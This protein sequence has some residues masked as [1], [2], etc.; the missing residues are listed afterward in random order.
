VLLVNAVGRHG[1]TD[2]W[3]ARA[4][5]PPAVADLDGDHFSVM[6]AR[7]AERLAAMLRLE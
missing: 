5:D 3:V 6:Q 2:T 4:V 7:N 1:G